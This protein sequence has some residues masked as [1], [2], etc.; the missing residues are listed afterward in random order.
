MAE[1]HDRI[2]KNWDADDWKAAGEGE[3]GVSLF[4]IYRQGEYVAIGTLQEL[5]RRGQERV[6]KKE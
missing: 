5:D 2:R 1:I 6:A 3:E 4:T